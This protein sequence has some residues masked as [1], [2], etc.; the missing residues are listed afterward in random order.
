MRL[1]R[2][3]LLSVV[4]FVALCAQAFARQ[5]QAPAAEVKRAA[6]RVAGA[7]LVSG[8]SMDYARGL[9]DGFGGRLKKSG[10]DEFLKAV[11]VWK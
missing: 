10:L 2:N 4:V 11:G 5:S 3:S 1:I 7:V 8:R 6:E 9:T